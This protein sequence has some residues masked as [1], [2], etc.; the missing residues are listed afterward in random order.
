MASTYVVYLLASRSRALYVGVTSDLPRRLAEHRDGRSAHT[1][2]YR[3]DRL[4]R[5]ESYPTARDAIAR[6]KQVK[7]WRRS[8]K[9]ALVES[10]NPTWRELDASRYG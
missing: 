6:E 3:I 7:G 10:E 9:V 2:R 1:A 5:A 8:K 4:V